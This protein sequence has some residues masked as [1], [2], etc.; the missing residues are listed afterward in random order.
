MD[1]SERQREN[2]SWPIAKRLEPDSNVTVE[3]LE[4]PSKACLATSATEQGM[5]IDRSE[6]QP[7]KAHASILESLQP[8]SKVTV[9]S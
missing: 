8:D 6:A 3:R 5:Q 4:Q 2:A 7:S 1:E 9:K